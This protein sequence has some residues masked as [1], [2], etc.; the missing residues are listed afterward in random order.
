MLTS[1]SSV[2]VRC[3]AFCTAGAVR[4]VQQRLWRA[5]NVHHGGT[6]S[7]SFQT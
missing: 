7:I 1:E 5:A 4:C 3:Q 2:K 6:V